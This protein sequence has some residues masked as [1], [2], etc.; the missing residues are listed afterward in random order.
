MVKGALL[1]ADQHPLC[2]QQQFQQ[3]QISSLP[4]AA[5]P[6]AAVPTPPQRL[7]DHSSRH[8]TQR[9]ACACSIWVQLSTSTA[10]R[11]L[12]WRIARSRPARWI[13]SASG[14]GVTTQWELPWGSWG[15]PVSEWK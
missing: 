3:R 1:E 12:R 4:A 9:W 5:L 8:A 15:R 13:S 7:P 14:T 2:Q 6:A 11:S 10:G